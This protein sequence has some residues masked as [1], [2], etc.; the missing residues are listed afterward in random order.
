MRLLAF[1][2][3]VATLN[4]APPQVVAQVDLARY[5]GTWHEIAKFPNRF[6][7]GCG[8]TTATY[9][10]RSDGKVSVVNRCGTGEGKFKSVK[11]WAKVVDPTTRAK[12][13]VTFFWPF[14]GDYWILA[15]DPEYRHVLVGTPDRKYLWILARQPS[16]EK[17]AYES[18]T[19]IAATQGFD[20]SKIVRT[21]PCL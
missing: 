17:A 3:L 11:G 15:L 16:M 9:A 20:I 7:R 10:L 12:L 18:L 1:F 14:F 19:T 21:E 2:L 4:A 5:M 13:K 6:Q 8:C